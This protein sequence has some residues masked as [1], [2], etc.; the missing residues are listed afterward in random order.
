MSYT[1]A[2]NT[3]YPIALPLAPVIKP[4]PYFPNLIQGPL[5]IIELPYNP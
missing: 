5:R 3:F 2:D 4:Y 1:P